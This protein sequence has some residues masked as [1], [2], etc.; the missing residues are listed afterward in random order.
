MGVLIVDSIVGGIFLI[1]AMGRGTLQTSDLAP[2]LWFAMAG[3]VGQGLGQVASFLGIQ[4][5]GV[6]R[7]APIQGAAPIWSIFLAIIFLGERPGLLVL[8][9]AGA[10]VTGVGLLSQSREND[11]KGRIALG[12]FHHA[13]ISV[14]YTHLTLTTKA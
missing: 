6:S 13:I 8:I 11:G 2:V 1:A 12:W 4:R 5:M 14:S 9:G 10:V 7:A 3:C